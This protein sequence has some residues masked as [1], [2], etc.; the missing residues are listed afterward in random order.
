MRKITT[1]AVAI[2]VVSLLIATTALAE[3]KSGASAEDMEKTILRLL[4]DPM[5]DAIDDYFGQPR[6]YMNDQLLS[7]R[8]LP[9]RP[10]YEVVVQVETFYGP[11]N[12]PYGL[13]TMTFYISYGKVTLKDYVHKDQ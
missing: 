6:Q 7:V 1:L 13:E 12:P 11:H 4:S 10:Y 3:S 2:A 5:Y 9:D 8:K